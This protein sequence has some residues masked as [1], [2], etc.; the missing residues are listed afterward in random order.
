MSDPL[1]LEELDKIETAVIQ[2]KELN[3]HALWQLIAAARAH[4]EWRAVMMDKLTQPPQQS[5][6]MLERD[7]GF[8]AND[9][10]NWRPAPSSTVEPHIKGCLEH[11]HESG[12]ILKPSPD[13]GLVERLREEPEYTASGKD[14]IYKLAAD[15]I[16]DAHALLGQARGD[17]EDADAA[18]EAKDAEIE[19]W[20]GSHLQLELECSDARKAQSSPDAGLVE[21]L[22]ALE[23]D[24]PPFNTIYG[25]A[26][27]AL[28]AK[29]AEIERWALR[30]SEDMAAAH[31]EIERCEEEIKDLFEQR[32]RLRE[33]LEE[34]ANVPFEIGKDKMI[35]KARAALK[36]GDG[37]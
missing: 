37:E 35:E 16:T 12:A 8:C 5:D 20:R 6:G 4:L 15:A 9:W 25:R 2:Q 19:K 32:A 17:L 23:A 1:T 31:N 34:I 36:G 7:M 22:E 11:E 30:Y 24:G 29:D 27:D 33:A 28:E 13:A 3:G 21:E 18:L 14:R 10:S 26:A